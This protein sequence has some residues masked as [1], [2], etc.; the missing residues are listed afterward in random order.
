[1]VPRYGVCMDTIRYTLAAVC[2]LVFPILYWKAK[3][4]RL[5]A[6]AF[7]ALAMILLSD[8]A[9]QIQP[10]L[11]TAIAAIGASIMFGVA[12]YMLL[13]KSRKG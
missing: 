6:F 13:A 1:M 2:L 8:R 4:N 10:A 11:S 12:L 5:V 7:P 3:S 9:G